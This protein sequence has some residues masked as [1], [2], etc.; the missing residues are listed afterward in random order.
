L[1][2]PLL[3]YYR[4]SL[5]LIIGKDWKESAALRE[6]NP[7]KLVFTAGDLLVPAHDANGHGLDGCKPFKARAGKCSLRQSKRIAF[8]FKAVSMRWLRLPLIVIG[9]VVATAGSFVGN[10]G[11][12]NRVRLRSGNLVLVSQVCMRSFR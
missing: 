1:C 3:R 6:A 8:M 9:E 2:R 11:F 10:A 7:D 4:K 12:S 5:V